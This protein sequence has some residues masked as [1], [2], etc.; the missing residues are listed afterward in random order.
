MSDNKVSR[1]NFLKIT[2]AASGALALGGVPGL[3]ST[4]SLARRAQK[5]TIS[6]LT[7]GDPWD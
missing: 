7:V 4:G 3:K 5:K 1:R 6:V 2:G